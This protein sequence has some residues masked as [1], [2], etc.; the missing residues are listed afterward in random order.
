MG[1]Q[2]QQT[3]LHKQGYG[4][5]LQKYNGKR[6]LVYLNARRRVQGT[7]KGHD[8]YMNIVLDNAQEIIGKDKFVNI[9]KAVIR[10]NSIIRWDCL[11]LI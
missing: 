1:G 9:G 7:V 8:N 11:E 3:T 5:D 4:P 2:Q 6:L 10:G